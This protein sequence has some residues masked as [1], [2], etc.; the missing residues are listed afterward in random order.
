[1]KKAE[2]MRQARVHRL[3]CI[4]LGMALAQDG[5]REKILGEIADD[6][7]QSDIISDSLAAI[8]NQDSKSIGIML[9]HLRNWGIEVGSG[10]V[11]DAILARLKSEGAKRRYDKIISDLQDFD[12]EPSGVLIEEAE[13]ALN[14]MKELV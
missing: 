6:D 3:E 5:D 2:V 11:L 12:G 1:M 8:R 7:F 4:L 14:A 10:K 13:S 9:D